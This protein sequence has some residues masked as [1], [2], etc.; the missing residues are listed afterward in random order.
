M[1]RKRPI[2]RKFFEKTLAR[3]DLKPIEPIVSQH[4][5]TLQKQSV[6]DPRM[7]LKDFVRARR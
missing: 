1:K 5:H 6:V 2:W 4:I 3:V 7:S